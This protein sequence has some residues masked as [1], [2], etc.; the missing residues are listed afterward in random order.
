MDANRISLQSGQRTPAGD[1]IDTSVTRPIRPRTAAPSRLRTRCP[2]PASVKMSVARLQTKCPPPNSGQGVRFQS[3]I[4]TYLRQPPSRC[5]L[6]GFEKNVRRPRPSRCPSPGFGQN[7][8][9]QPP[10]SCPSPFS[11]Q[12]APHQSP[13]KMSVISLRT[14]C[15]SPIS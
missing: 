12:N 4:K 5:P 6:P 9:R 2:S 1:D 8:R 3:P 10:S 7:V 14:N 11:G 13:D 15:L